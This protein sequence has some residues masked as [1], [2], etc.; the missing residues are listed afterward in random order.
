MTK[1]KVI[2]C[3]EFFSK[4]NAIVVKN[5]EVELQETKIERSDCCW[6]DLETYLCYFIPAFLLTLSMLLRLKYKWKIY[7]R[8]SF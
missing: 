2:G 8:K 4:G 7:L 1:S 3:T 5:G 6:K